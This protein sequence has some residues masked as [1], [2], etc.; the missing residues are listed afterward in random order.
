V[1]GARLIPIV[2]GPP[3]TAGAS[4]GRA[5]VLDV[6]GYIALAAPA[7]AKQ[8]FFEREIARRVEQFGDLAQVF[9]TYE[10]RHAPSDPKPFQRGINAIQL[11]Q[12]GGRWW[13]VTVYWQD[14]TPERPL[15]AE[16]LH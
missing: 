13:L 6:P 4:Q 7:V 16:Y 11:L 1:P 15:P 12:S 14:E 2:S 10:S 8:G 3:G 9:S 5:I